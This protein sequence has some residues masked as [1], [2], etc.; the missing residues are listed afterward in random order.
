MNKLRFTA[1]VTMALCLVALGYASVAAE[2]AKGQPQPKVAKTQHPAPLEFK[3]VKMGS[4]EKELKELYTD[5]YTA[6][7]WCM[8][9][10]D[11]DTIEADRVCFIEEATIAA[12]EAKVFLFYYSDSLH[13]IRLTFG[14]GDYSQ[15]LQALEK[16]Y[17]AAIKWESPA[18]TGMGVK[19]T[20]K[21]ASW[22]SPSGFI[23][24]TKYAG[25]ISEST[26]VFSSMAGLQESSRREAEQA[27]A[28]A[29]DM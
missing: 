19:Y 29:K 11:A 4:S 28:A 14:P 9:T 10:K 3:G 1:A 13:Q 15:V 2:P 17:G 8:S 26:V 16:K 6:V 27:K 7:I 22:S 5:S 20:N 24:A 18:I 12:V 21:T 25:K 23:V